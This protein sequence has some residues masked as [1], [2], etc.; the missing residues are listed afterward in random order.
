MEK[1]KTMIIGILLISISFY[2][3][4]DTL[5]YLKEKDPIMQ[6]IKKSKEKY[7]I[8]FEN[9]EIIGN[10]IIPGKKGKT[11]DYQKSFSDMKKY[12]SY[13]EALIRLKEVK[14]T[15]SIENNYDKYIIQGNRN[16]RK[17]AIIFTITEENKFKNIIKILENKK[18]SG[19]FFIDGTI[20][21]KNT[22][23]IKKHS[24]QEYEILSYQESYHKPFFKTSISYLENITKKDTKYCYTE[25]DNEELLKLCKNLKHH[26]IKPTIKIKKYLY[27]EVKQNISNGLI[28][29]IDNNN[30]IEKEL[31]PTID[32]IKQKDYELVNLRELLT[33]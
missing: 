4:N 32:Y 26:T 28:I 33:E 25:D 17:I 12:G 23:F 31:S 5:N 8:I 1:I 20:L 21:E 30:Y 22:C 3:I 24:T 14:P 18:V 7:K 10:N 15:I 29:S 2:I 11:I 13:N 6:N 19:T 16:K 27:K 9:A